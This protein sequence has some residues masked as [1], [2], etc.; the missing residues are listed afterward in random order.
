MLGNLGNGNKMQRASM[1]ALGE[2]VVMI[3]AALE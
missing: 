2:T 1:S 3:I